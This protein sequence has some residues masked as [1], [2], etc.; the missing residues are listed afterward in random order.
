MKCELMKKTSIQPEAN[1][2]AD[3]YTPISVCGDYAKI[4]FQGTFFS[5]PILWRAQIRTLSYQCQIDS[6]TTGDIQQFIDIPQAG[7]K[8]GIANIVLGLNID[9]INKAAIL[10]SIILV[11]QYKNLRPG[12]HR[13]GE[14]LSVQSILNQ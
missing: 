5:K 11:R 1:I 2:N 3:E 6:M 4:E 8:D 9:Q 14:T 10:S 7:I 13:Y 12:I